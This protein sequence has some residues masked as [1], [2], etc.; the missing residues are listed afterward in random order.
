MTTAPA[1]RKKFYLPEGGGFA[2]MRLAGSPWRGDAQNGVALGVLMAHTLETRADTGGGRLAR[3]TLD[4]MRPAPAQLT[5]VTWRVARAGRRVRLL[6]GILE[7]GGVE[8]VRASALFVSPT[9]PTPPPQP[10]VSPGAPPD[11]APEPPFVPIETGLEMRVLRRGRLTQA[12]ERVQ[13]SVWVRLLAEAVPGGGTSTLAAAIAI[14]D[15]G[16]AS[17]REYTADWTSPN[18]DIAIHFSRTPRG[19]WVHAA[20]APM[21]LGNGV[22]VIDH[23]LSDVDGPFARAHQTIFYTP[24]RGAA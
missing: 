1:R 21:V 10:L 17:L 5:Q 13:Q 8:A 14:A 23:R 16:G 20:T 19:E 22:A 3:F 15:T 6:E 11:E 12:G 24:R 9:G 18:L 2:P 4:I 7:A